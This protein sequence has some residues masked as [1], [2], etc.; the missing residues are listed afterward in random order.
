MLSDDDDDAANR[1]ADAELP[2]SFTDTCTAF[3]SVLTRRT[4][5]G[6]DAALVDEHDGDADSLLLPIMNAINIYTKKKLKVH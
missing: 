6:A 5:A 3:L 2:S 4:L 1:A